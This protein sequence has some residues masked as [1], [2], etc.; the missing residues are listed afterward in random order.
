MD[1]RLE[2]SPPRPPGLSEADYEQVVKLFWSTFDFWVEESGDYI[3]SAEYA[4]EVAGDQANTCYDES[5][6]FDYS[7][8]NEWFNK[9][10]QQA[11]ATKP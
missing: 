9:L 3:H 2:N 10:R 4:V 11:E 7:Q 1:E 5:K 8:L 6:D